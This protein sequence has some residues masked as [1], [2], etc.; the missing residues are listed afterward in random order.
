MTQRF[1]SV[2]DYIASFPDDTR[3]E[4]AKVRR[5]IRD[6]VPCA[7]EKISYGMATVTLDGKPLVYFAGWKKHVGV[8]PV[9]IGD[10]AFER[11]IGPYRAAKDTVRFPITQ[12]VPV[13]L[14][15]AIT[16]LCLA[17][18][19]RDAAPRAGTAQRAE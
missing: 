9:P 19:A 17:R 5:A 12:P 14:V 2:D 8:Y 13:E 16:R 4:L 3:A 10:A 18:R 7:A 15:A 6:V 1:T 11:A